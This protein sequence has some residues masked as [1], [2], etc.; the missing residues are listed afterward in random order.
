MY[1][2]IVD[3]VGTVLVHRNLATRRELFEAL[4]APYRE[5]VLVAL[6]C[7]FSCS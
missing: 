5:D 6:Q 3:Q 2:C 7:I 4:I 1:V